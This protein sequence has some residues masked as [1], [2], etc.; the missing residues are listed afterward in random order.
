MI[1]H[2]NSRSVY[3]GTDLKRFNEVRDYLDHEHIRYRYKVKNR[4]GQW[5]CR[6]TLRSNTGS[7]GQS[8]ECAHQYE[9]LVH[10]DD[11]EKIKLPC[12]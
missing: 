4:M 11:F 10:K 7:A 6:G 9:I 12:F 5:T 8:A 1:T 2:F 3:L